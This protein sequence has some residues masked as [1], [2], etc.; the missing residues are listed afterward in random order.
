[1]TP[2]SFQVKIYY[3]TFQNISVLE[4]KFSDFILLLIQFIELPV[5]KD[6]NSSGLQVLMQL[7][8]L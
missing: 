5:P 4:I 8:I 6:S 3:S 7:L 2:M 1:M